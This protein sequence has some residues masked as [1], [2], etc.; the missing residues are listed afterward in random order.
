MQQS[1][2]TF[3]KERQNELTMLSTYEVMDITG[4]T[5]TAALELMHVHGYKNGATYL[6]SLG[7]LKRVLL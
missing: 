6:I 2:I 4:M 3:P 1:T 5:Y 7:K